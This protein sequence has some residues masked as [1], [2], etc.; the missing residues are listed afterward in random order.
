MVCYTRNVKSVYSMLQRLPLRLPN[1]AALPQEHPALRGR[2]L[3]AMLTPLAIH[4]GAI[5][6]QL[7]PASGAAIFNF[8]WFCHGQ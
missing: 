8:S 1:G 6:Q 3:P 4:M 2:H 7:V 5:T